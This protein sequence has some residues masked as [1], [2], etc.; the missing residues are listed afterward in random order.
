[1]GERERGSPGEDIGK[2]GGTVS[3]PPCRRTAPAT[4][5]PEE[6]Q[7]WSQGK[8]A[9][10]AILSLQAA[11]RE[12][13]EVAEDLAGRGGRAAGRDARLHSR[14]WTPA[15]T[16]AVDVRLHSRGGCPPT[17]PRWMSAY[18]AAVDV[19]LHRRGGC[20]P[21]RPQWTSAYT[22]AVDVRLHSRGGCPPTQP[23]WTSAYTAAVDVR[24]HGGSRGR[25]PTPWQ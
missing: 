7:R 18:T 13:L 21:T 5:H 11:V 16:A 19:R 12:Y 6:A 24:L 17:P 10:E 8:T 15:Y 25:A 23:Q 4:P 2:T 3:R 1:V 14:G 20:P 22:A 9:R